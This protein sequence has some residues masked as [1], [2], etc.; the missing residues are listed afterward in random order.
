MVIEVKGKNE[1]G[2]GGDQA[3][4]FY[5]YFKYACVGV[6]DVFKMCMIIN[7]TDYIH[8]DDANNP[9]DNS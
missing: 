2:R 8:I 4:D 9:Q 3:R 7:D 1:G 5:M 6:V